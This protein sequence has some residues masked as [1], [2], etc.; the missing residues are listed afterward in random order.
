MASEWSNRLDNPDLRCKNKCGFYGNPM[1]QGYCSK[2]YKEVVSHE[3]KPSKTPAPVAKGQE[4]DAGAEGL[5]FAKFTRR[6]T[7]FN[8]AK[9]HGKIFKAPLKIR[10]NSNSGAQPSQEEEPSKSAKTRR[11]SDSFNEFMKTLKKPA[12]QDIVQHLKSFKRQIVEKSPTAT[13]EELSDLVQEFYR[14]TSE[15]LVTHPLFKTMSDLEQEE[16]MD[17]IE[18]HLTTSIYRYVFAPPS[19]DDDIKDLLFVRRINMLHWLEPSILDVTLDLSNIEVQGIV[20]QA[21]QELWN[22]ETRKAP[23]D[24]LNC[25]TKSCKLLLDALRISHGG[26]ASADEFVPGLIF[27]VIHTSPQHLQSNINYITRFSNPMR[28]MSGEC[29]YYFTN[30]C[31]AVTFIESISADKLKMS[32]EDFNNKMG[33]VN[34][35]TDADLLIEEYDDEEMVENMTIIESCCEAV[36]KIN[37]R[38]QEMSNETDVMM[39]RLDELKTGVREQVQSVLSGPPPQSLYKKKLS[40]VVSKASHLPT[41]TPSPQI[42]PRVPHY[43]RPPLPVNPMTSSGTYYPPPTNRMA[44]YQQ[45]MPQAPYYPGPPGYVPRPGSYVPPPGAHAPPVRSYF[46]PPNFPFPPPGAHVPPPA[47]IG[48]PPPAVSGSHTLVPGTDGSRSRT[49]SSPN[50]THTSSPPPLMRF[51]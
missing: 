23:Q 18:K 29:G 27:L 28:V 39:S 36:E 32:V 47:A 6:K 11:S 33:Y 16:T 41:S 42:S 30:L 2:C 10:P 3:G 5:G 13:I 45:P 50:I 8:S 31:G 14:S 49:Q 46:P 12:A 34:G 22:V 43:V 9:G 35:K 24:K 40:P 48:V 1:Y 25:I 44:N 51:N 7:L 37:E 26:P 20:A 38:L 15:R 17:G 19:C 21:R 4:S